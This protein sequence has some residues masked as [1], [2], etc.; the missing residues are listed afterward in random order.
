MRAMALT[1]WRG[2][3][4]IAETSSSKIWHLILM[5]IFALSLLL[6]L[7]LLLFLI[8]PLQPLVPAGVVPVAL[9]VVALGRKQLD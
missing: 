6:L 8:L 3:G 4:A 1:Y 7:L 5:L 9:A 2:I